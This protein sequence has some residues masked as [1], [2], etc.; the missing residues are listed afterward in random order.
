M[1][2]RATRTLGQQAEQVALDYLLT[3]GLDL[4]ARNFNCR[5]GEID[6]VMEHAG[7]LVFVEVR[8]RKQNRFA[9][10]HETV[11]WRKQKKLIASASIFLARQPR[12]R[13]RT[14]RFDVIAMD[15][16]SPDEFRLQ[17]LRDAFRPE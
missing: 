16:A 17:W 4:V 10:A 8:Y 14:M 1:A 5:L 9:S 12:F 11:D 15:G 6:L 7:C 3:N 13:M 2:A